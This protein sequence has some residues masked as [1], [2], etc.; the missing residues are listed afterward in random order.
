MPPIAADGEISTHLEWTVGR[1]G[2]HP[3][4]AAALLDQIDRLSSHADVKRGIALAL[5]GQKIEEVPL[6][7]QRDELA[8]RRQMG[9]IREGIFVATEDGAD[10]DLLLVRKPEKFVERVELG[11]DV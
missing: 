11:H 8:A 7:H 1:V 10:I 3:G 9:E 6:R 5:L 2:A 4:H